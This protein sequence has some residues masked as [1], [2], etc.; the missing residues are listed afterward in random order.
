VHQAFD[1]QGSSCTKMPKVV[2]P[3]MMPVYSSPSLSL[4]K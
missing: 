4:M 3:V 2:T 1:E